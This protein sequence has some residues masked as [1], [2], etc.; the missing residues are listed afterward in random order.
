MTKNHLTKAMSLLLSLAL[1]LGLLSVTASTAYAQDETFSEG[2]YTAEVTKPVMSG[3]VT[4]TITVTFADGQYQYQTGVKLSGMSD[5]SMN[6]DQDPYSASGTYTVSGNTLTLTGGNL[7]SGVVND[8]GSVTLTGVISQFAFGKSSE[9]TV[10]KQGG[11]SS[12]KYQDNLKSGKY[13]LTEDSYASSAM[14]KLPAYITIDTQAKTLRIQAAKD[15]AE[16]GFGTYTFNEAT[17]V[18]TVTYTENTTVGAT[19][20]FVYSDN[21]IT[22]T[23]PM[24]YGKAMMNVTDDDGN[25]I[26]YTAKLAEESSKYQDELKSGKYLLTEDSYDASAMMKMPAYITIDTEAKTF[27]VQDAREGKDLAEKGFGTYTFDEETGVYTVTYTANT[28]VGATTTF[29]YSDS[30]ITFTSPLYFGMAKLNILDDDG[31]FIP[32]TAKPVAESSKYQDNLK[33]GKYLLTE[34]S[35]DASAMMK[36]PAY[37][38][39]DTEA[40]TFNVQ[41]AREGKDL[42]EK[43]FGTYTFDEETGV[44]TV[45]YTANTSVGAIT[46]FTYSDSGITFTSPLYFG[47]ARINILDDDGNF[48]S[49][50]AKLV[51]EERPKP[52]DGDK[53][54]ATDPDDSSKEDPKPAPAPGDNGKTDN[55]P[56]TGDSGV[57][58][59]WALLAVVSLSGAV[60]LIRKKARVH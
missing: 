25:F 18:Y 50:T 20:T 15:L 8:D 43:G 36:M 11:S 45:T 30:G 35:Y 27:N 19:T 57:S 24:Y 40:K 59:V 48:I 37:I 46:T 16:K 21:G 2:T 4:Y 39:I 58:T 47:M 7:T 17:G 42:A 23:S 60:I 1:L 6:G 22:F 34:D 38:T 49:Y 14:M 33:S 9:F 10:S 53:K 55:A 28:S 31:N 44:Y 54:P 13:A 51:S 26:P 52:D 5:E 32:Y 12:I 3:N 41:D 29:T 56:Q